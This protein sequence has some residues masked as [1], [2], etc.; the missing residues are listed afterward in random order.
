MGPLM[1]VAGSHLWSGNEN[2]REFHTNEE[3]GLR[4]SFETEGREFNIVPFTLEVGQVSFHHCLTIHGSGPNRSST[5]RHS[6]SIH[7]Q[8]AFN[9]YRSYQQH[10]GK[11]AWHRND[12]LCRPR[13]G[14]P[15]YT[16]PDFCPV[17][18]KE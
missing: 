5:S 15:D 16:D 12:V 17:L 7:L 18:W 4:E 11:L 1:V 3:S 9:S 6:L 14:Q 8:D 13:S 10:D 2:L